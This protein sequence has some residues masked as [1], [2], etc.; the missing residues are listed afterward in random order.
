[1]ADETVDVTTAAGILEVQ[2]EQIQAMVDEGLLTPLEG[3][4]QPTF[5]TAEVHA[6]K[7]LG[8]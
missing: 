5:S 2:P 8:G 4:D 1:M 6:T 7:N 3:H